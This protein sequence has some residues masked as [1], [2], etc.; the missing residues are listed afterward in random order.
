[1]V[2]TSALGFTHW[3]LENNLSGTCCYLSRLCTMN[4]SGL[5]LISML[6]LSKQIGPF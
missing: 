2:N 3:I 5:I 1:M 6:S 4:F